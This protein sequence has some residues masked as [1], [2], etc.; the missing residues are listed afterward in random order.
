MSQQRAQLS[1][2]VVVAAAALIIG[3]CHSSPLAGLGVS[4]RSGAGNAD[5]GTDA[6]GSAGGVT[7]KSGGSPSAGAG[8]GADSDGACSASLRG[9]PSGWEPYSLFGSRC[10]YVPPTQSA[11]PPPITWQDCASKAATLKDCRELA[12]TWQTDG[13]NATGG[14]HELYVEADGT[15]VLQIRN[16]YQDNSANLAASLALVAEAD[17]RVRQALWDPYDVAGRPPYWLL[18]G[19]VSSG[20]ATWSLYADQTPAQYAAFGGA[21]SALKPTP[22]FALATSRGVAR[23]GHS[24]F[25]ETTGTIHV[26]GWN[27]TDYGIIENS[28]DSNMPRWTDDT[29]YFSRETP[30]AS[31]LRLWTRAAGSIQLRSYGADTTRA[32]A[33]LGTDGKSLVWLEGSGRAADSVDAPYPTRAIYTAPFT[34]APSDLAPRR[35]RSWA[36]TVIWNSYP[37]A[38]GCG[39]AAF[40]HPRPGNAADPSGIFRE[41]L[42][43]RLKDGRSWT[44]DAPTPFV[45]DTAWDVPLAVTCSEV[46]AAV[47]FNIRRVRIDSLGD[48]TPPD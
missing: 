48:G 21:D 26:W 38:V 34:T 40:F 36:P 20:K 31:E 10:V 29:L 35:L 47:G 24:F 22:L 27:G 3:G 9:V 7:N 12:I 4:G 14:S 8:A 17:G 45:V 23:P 28:S 1:H 42:L 33:Q 11:L 2:Q 13:T 41:L 6:G 39:Y 5:A 32:A 25:A 46:F 44:L 16:L 18:P 15:V 30:A 37:P 43:V 19:G